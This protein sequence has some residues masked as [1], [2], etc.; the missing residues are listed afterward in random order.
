MRSLPLAV[1]AV[2]ALALAAVATAT[3]VTVTYNGVSPSRSVSLSKN[4]GGT[5]SNFTAGLVNLTGAVSNPT[6]LRGAFQAFCID[7][8][9]SIS[10]GNT[11]TNFN[12]ANLQDAPIPT[13]PMGATKAGQI[14]ELWGEERSTLS[15]SDSYAAFQIAIWEIVNDTGLSLTGG[16]F[17][18]A[19]GTVR[20]LAQNMLNKVDGVGP[21]ASLYAIASPTVQDFVVPVIPAPGAAALGLMGLAMAAR[22][23]R[24]N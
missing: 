19:S 17:R 5:Y 22:R 20:T 13:S 8:N 2:A 7:I 11:Y 9:Q 10:N 15:S 23:N 3:P 14:A 1:S 4:S 24:R 6:D 12:T 18:A 21:S 16:T